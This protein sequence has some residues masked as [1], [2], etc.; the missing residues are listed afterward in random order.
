MCKFV[1]AL[2]ELGDESEAGGPIRFVASTGGVKRDGKDLDP[3]RW[4]LGNYRANP[5]VLWGHDYF[6]GRLPVGR[7]EVSIGEGRLVA[8]VTFDR[9]DV[10]ATEVERKYRAGF[11]HAVSVGWDEVAA[12]E[13]GD[14]VPVRTLSWQVKPEDIRYDLLDV[15]AVPVP[16]DPSALMERERAGLRRLRSVLDEMLGEREGDQAAEDGDEAGQVDGAARAD[17]EPDGQAWVKSVH[18]IFYPEGVD[19]E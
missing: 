4:M 6:G 3:S 1:R 5:V 9:G 2:A 11:L 7:A 8:D 10:F 14:W 13:G 18:R 19:D 17:S 16:G 12:D 15:S